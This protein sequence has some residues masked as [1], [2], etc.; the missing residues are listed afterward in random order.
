[1]KISGTWIV[2]SLHTFREGDRSVVL[3]DSSG[4]LRL[5]LPIDKE[6]CDKLSRLL[7]QDVSYE[8]TINLDEGEVG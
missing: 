7:G 4:E 2:R 1:M 6:T 5:E 8:L 3:K